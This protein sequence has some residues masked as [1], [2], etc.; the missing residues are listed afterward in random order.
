MTWFPSVD[1]PTSKWHLDRGTRLHHAPSDAAIATHVPQCVRINASCSPKT[2]DG[3]DAGR[4]EFYALW[5]GLLHAHRADKIR[6]LKILACSTICPTGFHSAV[7]LPAQIVN[8]LVFTL[9]QREHRNV[10][11]VRLEVSHFGSPSDYVRTPPKAAAA[12]LDHHST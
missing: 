12:A 1:V 9:S 8:L 10:T 5:H 11:H 6:F 7:S 2:V 3:D 4:P